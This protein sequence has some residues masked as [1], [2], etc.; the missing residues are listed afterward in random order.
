MSLSPRSRDL[1]FYGQAGL[2]ASSSFFLARVVSHME[3]SLD[4]ENNLAGS[5][6]NLPP[7]ITRPTID[8][9]ET[10]FVDSER[11]E[12]LAR[13]ADCVDEAYAG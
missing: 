9:Y 11:S 3:R 7:L 1:R 13:P 5:A 12:G 8:E 10:I 6:T 2:S 4:A